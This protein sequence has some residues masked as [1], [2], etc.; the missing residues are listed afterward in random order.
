MRHFTGMAESTYQTMLERKPELT[1]SMP[2]EELEPMLRKKE[3]D[4]LNRKAEIAETILRESNP[5]SW[6]ELDE[7]LSKAEA[8]STELATD[9]TLGRVFAEA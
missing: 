3:E 8:I 4:Y 6:A 7:A 1:R 5:Q 9:E 2:L